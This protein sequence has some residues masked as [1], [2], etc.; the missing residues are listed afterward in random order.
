VTD[1]VDKFKAEIAVLKRQRDALF[2]NI[3]QSEKALLSEN[4]Q[5]MA[6]LGHPSVAKLRANIED[7]KRQAENLTAVI[8]EK[9]SL[10]LQSEG[11]LPKKPE[12]V[13]QERWFRMQLDTQVRGLTTQVEALER[14]IKA[15]WTNLGIAFLIFVVGLAA[16]VLGGM[17][18]PLMTKWL[19]GQ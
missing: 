9:E 12:G 1:E 7:W 6:E 4:W 10:E 13:D 11:L 18:G 5:R 3:Q 16:A 15:R 2:D 17:F 19:G 8:Q 14:Q